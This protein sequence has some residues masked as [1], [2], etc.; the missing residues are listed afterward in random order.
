MK[1]VY[2]SF[3]KI[4]VAA[5]PEEV[6]RQKLLR[7]LTEDLGYPKEMIVIEKRLSE[8]P[9]LQQR[10]K[11]VPDRRL[12][13]LCYTKKG[14][15]L[16]PLILIECKAEKLHEKMFSQVEGYNSYIG[17]SFVALVGAVGAIVKWKNGFI[18]AIPSY[19]QATQR[20]L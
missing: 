5:T 8:L 11:A 19:E 15:T 17:A 7:V 6:V 18:G 9:H 14:E 16:F 10:K 1:K 3:R 12:D 2:D 13:I 20:V 4:Y